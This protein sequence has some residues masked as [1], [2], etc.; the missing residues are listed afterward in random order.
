M[1]SEEL[2]AAVEQHGAWLRG[3]P[4]GVRAN[5]NS[6]DLRGADLRGADLGDADLSGAD[7]GDA[8]LSGADLRGA[9][10]S[11]AYLSD[12]N[13]SGANLRGANLRGA[14]LVSADLSGADLRGT[15][16]DPAAA[17][18]P[19]PDAALVAAGLEIDGP[20]VLGWRT[21]RSVH[22]G[23]TVYAPGSAHV[24]PRFSVDAGTPCHP[25]IYLASLA[26]LEREFGMDVPRVRCRALRAELV[27]AGDK[28]RAKRLWIQCADGSW[29]EVA[30]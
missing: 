6:A 24:A 30:P 22:V 10:L 7:L 21:A 28:W 4:A 1:T 17:P 12:A 26:W 29:P 16:L 18:P 2:A 15:A 11:D 19:L 27:H 5:L 8:D 25:G 3:E 14:Y 23:S 9:Y 13:L 20:W